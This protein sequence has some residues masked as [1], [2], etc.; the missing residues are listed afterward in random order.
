M[1]GQ[2]GPQRESQQEAETD[3]CGQQELE[4]SELTLL[5]PVGTDENRRKMCLG[6]TETKWGVGI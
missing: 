5:Q 6:A 3:G 2:E 4:E 1:G